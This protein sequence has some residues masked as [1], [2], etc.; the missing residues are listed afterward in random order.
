MHLLDV[1]QRQYAATE[2]SSSSAEREETYSVEPEISNT[3]GSYDFG[4]VDVSSTVVTGRGCFTIPTRATARW[5]SRFRGTDL[6]YVGAAS[7]PSISVLVLGCR[8]ERCDKD[9][10]PRP[11]RGSSRRAKDNADCCD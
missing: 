7:L 1:R 3:P 2:P 10:F 9:W 11:A 4:I 5:T 8:N 6:T